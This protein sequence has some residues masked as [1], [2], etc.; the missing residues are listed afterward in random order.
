MDAPVRVVTVQNL[1]RGTS[2]AGAIAFDSAKAR[3]AHRRNRAG[4]RHQLP[5][6]WRGIGLVVQVGTYERNIRRAVVGNGIVLGIIRRAAPVTAPYRSSAACGS[7][8]PLWAL[9]TLWPLWPCR[10]SWTG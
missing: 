2:S 1:R 7:R 9:N 5:L 8:W 4:L 6:H 10:S 3:D